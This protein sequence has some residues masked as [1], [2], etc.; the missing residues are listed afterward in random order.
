MVAPNLYLA[1]GISGAAQHISGMRNAG[2]IVAINI[3]PKAAIFNYSDVCIVED[4]T[5]FIPTV[6]E[7]F[8][9]LKAI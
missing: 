2:F 1:C 7:T 9:K 6:I 4:L 8:E 3:D 5:T